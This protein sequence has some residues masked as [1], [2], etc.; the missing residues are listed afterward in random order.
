MADRKIH[1]FVPAG[2]EYS[3][4]NTG[5]AIEGGG[6]SQ[7]TSRIGCEIISGAYEPGMRMPDEATMLRRYAISRTALREAYSKLAAKGLIQAR[8]KIG[9]HVRPQSD[10]NMLD[11]DVLAWHMQT[12]PAEAIASDLYALRRMVEPGAAAMAAQVRS[13]EAL[14]AM[15]QAYSDMKLCSQGDGDLIEADFRFHLA[16]LSATGNHFIGAFSALIHAAM[17][18]TFGLSWR[19]AAGIKQDRMLQHGNVLDAIRE[20]RADAAR[21]G[22]ETLLDDSINDVREAL[23]KKSNL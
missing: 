14:A 23:G 17:V 2:G 20:Q 16:I 1:E 9:T 3:G 15:S 18:S 19:G 8:P 13:D 22:M 10:W 12:M 21:T 4:G 11:S 7:L 5:H 6:P